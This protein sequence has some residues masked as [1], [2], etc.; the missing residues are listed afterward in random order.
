[1]SIEP[2]GAP[3]PIVSPAAPFLQFIAETTDPGPGLALLP[4][5]VVAG[6][7]ELGDNVQRE[8]GNIFQRRHDASA[9]DARARDALEQPTPRTSIWRPKGLQELDG[10]VALLQLRHAK[11]GPSPLASTD[12]ALRRLGERNVLRPDI[13]KRLQAARHLLRQVENISA[14]AGADAAELETSTD[15]TVDVVL[16]ATQA[17]DLAVLNARLTAEAEFIRDTALELFETAEA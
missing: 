17:S 6:S 1:M 4:S 13:V 10:L 12:D 9:L 16:R 5:R 14:I 8:L 2:W 3:G 15:A 7:S 11:D